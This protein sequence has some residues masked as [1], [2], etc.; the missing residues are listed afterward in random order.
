[1]IDPFKIDGPAQIGLS[2]GRSSGY[3]MR[4]ILDAHDG[5]LPDDVFVTFQNTGKEREKTLLFVDRMDREWGLNVQW[6][7]WCGVYGSGL[8]WKLVDFKSAS[9]NSE[10]FDMFL[11]YYDDYRRIEKNEPPILPN[12]VNRMCSDRMKIKASIWFMRDVQ[13]LSEWDAVLGI[14]SDER[15]RYARAMA[16]NEKGANR[17]ESVLPM[18]AAGVDHAD[19]KAFWKSQPFDLGIDSD[20]GNCDGCFL[21]HENKLLRS[22]RAEPERADW[23]IAQEERTGQKFIKNGM[24]YKQMKWVAL[25]MNK[26]MPL[27]P[28]HVADDEESATDCF[29]G[30]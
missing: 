1:M 15:S 2:G 27:I 13:G 7:E 9:R 26:Q 8:Q 12:V 5:K 19:V 3:M 17:Y 6:I 10:P 28:I 21:K 25:Q 18:Y 11:R 20:D 30:G 16:A 14:R 22:F 24:T 29:C 4:R 23:W